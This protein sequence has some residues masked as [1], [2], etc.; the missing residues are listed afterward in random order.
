[1]SVFALSSPVGVIAMGRGRPT[2]LIGGQ[3]TC[4]ILEDRHRDYLKRHG[5]EKSQCYRDY[6]DSLIKDEES[7]E[8]QLIREIEELDNEINEKIILKRQKEELLKERRAN[9][10]SEIQKKIELEEFEAKKYEYVLGCKDTMMKR[11]PCTK[12]WLDHLLEAFHFANYEEA[13]E[14]VKRVWLDYGV[15]EKRVKTFF[16][17]KPE[18]N[19]HTCN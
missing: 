11:G 10:E 15:P 14:Y 3:T 18:R 2:K 16:D 7:P 19:R 1:M 8:E 12:M 13:K 17:P 4:V 5:L 9:R 6:L